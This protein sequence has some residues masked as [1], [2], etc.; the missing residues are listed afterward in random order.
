[1]LRLDWLGNYMSMLWWVFLPSCLLGLTLAETLTLAFSHGLSR[2]LVF[3]YWSRKKRAIF[4]LSWVTSALYCSPR[5]DMCAAGKVAHMQWCIFSV[6]YAT[7]FSVVCWDSEEKSEFA[8]LLL[9]V[10]V[11]DGVAQASGQL[12]ALNPHTPSTRTCTHTPRALHVVCTWCDYHASILW[13]IALYSV[14]ALYSLHFCSQ[15]ILWCCD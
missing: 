1:M 6:L 10:M 4:K 15:K 14:K 3:T 5:K 7:I 12:P 9:Q 2:L 8:C 13:V 11:M